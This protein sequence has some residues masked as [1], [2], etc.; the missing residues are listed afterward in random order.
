[1]Y[2]YD[3]EVEEEDED[4]DVDEFDEEATLAAFATAAAWNGSVNEPAFNAEWYMAAAA[5]T[6]GVGV[7]VGE[8]L[9]FKI[10]GDEGDDE[11]SEV[12]E[13]DEEDGGPLFCLLCWL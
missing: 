12:E 11:E 3:D 13:T 5:T 6:A 9:P 10:G 4:D 2:E 8:E 1:M 7:G